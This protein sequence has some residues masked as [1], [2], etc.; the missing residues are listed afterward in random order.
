VLLEKNQDMP[1]WDEFEK[2]VNQR[3]GPPIRG[4]ALGKLIQLGREMTVADYQSHFLALVNHYK[5]LFKPHQINI[6]T[7]GLHDPLKTD[8]ELEQPATLEKSDSPSAC[9]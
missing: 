7:T 2:L 1:T 9:L 5:G 3:F 6:F 4:N 8:V